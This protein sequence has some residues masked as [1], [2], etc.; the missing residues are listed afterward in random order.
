MNQSMYFLQPCKA[1]GKILGI[2]VLMFVLLNRE[3]K[4]EDKILCTEQECAFP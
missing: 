2:S 1:M 3:K 4:T